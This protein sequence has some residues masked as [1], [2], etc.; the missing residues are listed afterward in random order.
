MILDPNTTSP[1]SF[2]HLMNSVILPRPIAFVTTVS[3]SGRPNAAPFSWY[4]GL[5]VRP[6]LLGVS[7][8]PRD[9]QPKDTLRNIRDTREFVVNI[10]TQA[11][12]EQIV[13]ASGDWPEDV[14]ELA[15]VGLTAIP[16]DLVRPPR[17]AESPVNFECRL[18]RE[19]AV[20]DSTFVI[21]EILRAHVQD[22]VL[23]E[24]RVEVTKLD[25]LGRLG[26]SQFT[27]LGEVL[28]LP[29]PKVE[30]LPSSG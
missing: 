13:R 8:S 22:G 26:G 3:P 27:T 20:G 28:H 12:A 6:P 19:I 16:A 10:V 1:A 9:G 15:L 2:S 25:P 23:S 5:A 17:V 21:G 11:M 4:C 29:R 14:N 24:G 7:L 30:R 18:D